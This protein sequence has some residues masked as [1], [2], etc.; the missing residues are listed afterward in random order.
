[1]G[2]FL[3]KDN[4]SMQQVFRFFTYKRN[5]IIITHVSDENSLVFIKKGD[6]LVYVKNELYV[7][8]EKQK[9]VFDKKD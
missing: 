3:Q 4:I 1:M 6:T 2:V 8:N 5:F 9:L 7:I